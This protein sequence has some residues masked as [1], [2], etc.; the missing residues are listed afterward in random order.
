MATVDARCLESIALHCPQ[1]ESL[2]LAIAKNQDPVMMARAYAS[3]G[4]HCTRLKEIV[5]TSSSEITDEHVQ[6]LVNYPTGGPSALKAIGLALSG[7]A[8]DA[9]DQLT[10]RALEAIGLCC[11]RLKILNL[12]G[13]KNIIGCH[14]SYL[15]PFKRISENSTSS[16]LNPRHVKFQ[17]LL[18]LIIWNTGVTQRRL[19]EWLEAGNGRYLAVLSWAYQ[20]KILASYHSDEDDTDEDVL[21]R[22]LIDCFAHMERLE[23]VCLDRSM[24]ALPWHL[25]PHLLNVKQ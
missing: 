25:Y 10:G 5:W 9:N 3:I 8:G 23:R 24:E 7:R 15:P 19:T 12:Y 22:R 1:L 21:D 2:W 11:P 4:R 16:V 13:R 18:K 17:G 14:L 20:D 6:A